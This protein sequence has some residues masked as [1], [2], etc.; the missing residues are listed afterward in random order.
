ME[1]QPSKTVEKA[2]QF[3]YK[4]KAFPIKR[5]E[6]ITAE[7]KAKEEVNACI[8]P[9]SHDVKPVF[10]NGERNRILFEGEE[11]FLDE[12]NSETIDIESTLESRTLVTQKQNCRQNLFKIQSKFRLKQMKIPAK[13]LARKR[14]SMKMK[15][16][17]N[18]KQQK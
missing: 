16:Y 12:E 9:I 14:L 2:T 18:L 4:S 3:A 17:L 8:L 15:F 13:T 6:E 1:A 7:E 10:V 11:N 5:E